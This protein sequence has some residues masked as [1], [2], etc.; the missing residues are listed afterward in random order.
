[1]SPVPPER[2][3]TA[4]ATL[5]A[6]PVRSDVVV[7]EVPAPQRLAPHAVALAAE[8]HRGGGLLADGR[9][10]VLHDP[11]GQQAWEGDSRLVAFVRADIDPEMAADP[12]L[13][14]VGWSW[15]LDALAEHRAGHRAAG[16]TITR[17]ASHRFGSLASEGE[18]AEIEVRASWSPVE[19]DLA[20]HVA[21]WCDLLCV[22]AGLPPAG[23][24]TL[25]SPRR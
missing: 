16:G 1:M 6:A 17:T 23:V 3:R 7:R 20:P 14:A 24:A 25:R 21:A 11:A 13:G 8:L 2:F 22:A 15:L 19:L 4:V 12:M 5:R 9:L 10:V 18:L